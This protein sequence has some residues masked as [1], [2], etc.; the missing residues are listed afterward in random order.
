MPFEL[1]DGNEPSSS[2]QA[3]TSSIIIT[4]SILFY[5]IQGLLFDNQVIEHM[6]YTRAIQSFTEK[7]AF[8]SD[9]LELG[10]QIPLRFS[11]DVF[12]P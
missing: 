2:L 4:S 5:H 8:G 7:K 6:I 9:G 11:L 3:L 1:I 10:L 12:E